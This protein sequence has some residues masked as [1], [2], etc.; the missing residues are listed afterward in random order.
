MN[1]EAPVETLTVS[2]M[3]H[4]L[5]GTAL[6]GLATSIDVSGQNVLYCGTEGESKPFTTIVPTGVAGDPGNDRWQSVRACPLAQ[7]IDRVRL[8][9]VKVHCDAGKLNDATAD[10]LDRWKDV[11]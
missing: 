6:L 8:I 4:C 7:S 3:T 1:D 2:A 10:P 11:S 5:C 9:V